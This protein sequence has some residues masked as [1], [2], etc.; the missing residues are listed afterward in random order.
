MRRITSIHII[1][2][3]I[4][5]VGFSQN[6]LWTEKA[7]HAINEENIIDY[8]TE[9]SRYD[10]YELDEDMF[11]TTLVNAPLRFQQTQS[12]VL[13]EIPYSKGKFGVFE[14]FETQTLHPQLAANYP[15]IKSY[16][17]KSRNGNSD[18]L[19]LTVTPHGI[20]G[21]I[22]S[23]QGSVYI[24]PYTNNGTYFK[25]FYMADASFPPLVCH[26]EEQLEEQ[27]Q[28][29]LPLNNYENMVD[30]STFRLYQF[31]GSA[32]G[33]YSTFQVNE[34]GVSGGTDAQKKSAVLAAMTVS[35]DRVNGITENDAALSFQFFPQ[36]DV[37]IFLDPATD[38]FSNPGNAGTT[39]NENVSLTSSAS[40]SFDIGHVFSTAGGGLAALNSICNNNS[41]AGG[42]TGPIGGPAVGDSF[43]LVL[44]HEIGHQL[45][46][47][48][49]FN[50]S[51]S[52]N[53]TN[54]TAFETGNGVTVMSYSI[55]GCAPAVSSEDYDHYHAV[56]LIQIFNRISNTNCAQTSNISN[57]APTI[58]PLFNYTIP[59]Q[60]PFM[61][62]VQATDPDGDLLTYNWE[63]LDNEI[64]IQP[65]SA[66]SAGGPNFRG[67]NVTTASNRVFPRIETVLNNQNQ[68]TWEVLPNVERTMEFIVTVRDNNIL[69]GQHQQD[70]VNLTV[71][72]SGPFLVTSQNTTGIVW[73]A[74]STETVTWNVSGTDSAPV[75]ATNVDIILSTNGGISFD[76]VLASA[77]P[78]DG[79]HDII[80]PFD[81][82][83]DNCRLMVR[84]TGNVFFNVNQEEFNVNA[85]CESNANN[86]DVNIPDGAGFFDPVPGPPAESVITISETG[87][88]ESVNLQVN[89]SHSV[90]QELEIELES[91][92]GTV[93]KLMG[94]DIC[95]TDGINAIFDDG[96]IPLPFNG[97]DDQVVGVFKPVESLSA[98]NGVNLNG[99]W[100]LR[101]T[102]FLIG[103]IG[104]INNW[105]LEV[106]RATTV[107]TADFNENSFTLFPNPTTG[108]LKIS[109]TSIGENQDLEIYDLNGRLVKTYGLDAQT[110]AQNIDV[111]A[112]NQ[113]IYLVKVIQDG[114]SFVEKL[115]VK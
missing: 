105:S 65:P 89:V 98:F 51:C 58:S 88:V 7:E 95:S 82:I 54:A 80:V 19:R 14:I 90:L 64:T 57:N 104:T 81:V 29:L 66:A 77:T 71:D 46:A 49:T 47:T 103:N 112:L 31:S 97:C 22:F 67:Y 16:V 68:T 27:A 8:S 110:N 37:F 56:S 75:N 38:P 72:S 39:L 20:Y 50:N 84:G 60:T 61:L 73:T 43:D 40:S 33:E 79:T 70:G 5:S 3:L 4:F 44:A 96:G 2:L 108:T 17:G 11:K 109:L 83:G 62:D 30:D 35:L 41:K 34:A 48:H 9:V 6:T 69:G 25:V 93:V 111:N 114:K 23:S 92:D 76:H 113:G 99:N 53:R 63:Q 78:N 107:G 100:T 102:D 94:F 10:V 101:A 74:G 24:N 52:N 45:G 28:E 1:I 32:T 87:S 106:C 42:V 21:K 55:N 12:D 36:T 59:K 115:I 85:T 18:R 91:P 15:G 26:F 86:A 13:L